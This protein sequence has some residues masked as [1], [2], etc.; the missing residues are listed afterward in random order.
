MVP[1]TNHN[2]VALEMVGITSSLETCI[3]IHPGFGLHI[4]ITRI[5]R[6]KLFGPSPVGRKQGGR[7]DKSKR[8]TNA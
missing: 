4:T 3:P 2:R 6:F 8:L 7:E 5:L 1:S